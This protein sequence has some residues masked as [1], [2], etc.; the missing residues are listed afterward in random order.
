MSDLSQISVRARF[1]RFPA[2]LKGAFVIRGEDSDPHLV[3]LRAARAVRVG[4]PETRPIEIGPVTM[5]VVPHRDLF[6]PFEMPVSDLPP[7]WYGLECD[8]DVDGT[9]STFQGGKRFVVP[10]PRATVRRGAVRVDRTLALGD[11]KASI[12]QVDCG[13]DSIKL[14]LRTEPPSPP[15]V[16]LSAD[17]ETLEVLEVE[18]DQ[19]SGRTRVTA[20]PVMR[21]HSRLRVEVG[22]GRARRE[23]VEVDLV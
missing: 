20:Y 12:E 13:G 6:V 16:R 22:F 1:E 11:L 14:H 8:A 10:W 7:G 5:D 17:G 19:E 18:F 23:A 21:S 3:A 15:T 2:T 9:P 4:A